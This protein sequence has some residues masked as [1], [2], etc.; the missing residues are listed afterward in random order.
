MWTP[1]LTARREQRRRARAAVL[2]SLAGFV[3]LQAAYFLVARCVPEFHDPEYCG[4]LAR[5]QVR[6]AEHPRA[7]PLVLVLG[8]SHVGMGVRP[9]VL[10]GAECPESPL[11]FNFGINAGTP[12]VSLVCL[13][14]LL[15]EGIRPDWVL[16]ETSALQLSADG[17][18]A[19]YHNALPLVFV[20]W[21][22][23]SV[24]GRYYAKPRRLWRDWV[25]TQSLPWFSHRQYLLSYLCRHWLPRGERQDVRWR[26]VDDWG[27]QRVR[28]HE[29]AYEA[30]LRRLEATRLACVEDY[31]HFAIGDITRR[32]LLEIVETCRRRHIGVAFLRMPEARVFQ[33]WCPPAVAD[34][35]DTFLAGLSKAHQI[36]LIDARDWVGE[37][38]F[39]DGHHLNPDGAEAFMRRFEAEVLRPLR[40]GQL[41][42]Q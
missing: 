31:R 5:L 28:G 6:L 25:V 29:G 16:V 21:Y 36:P 42:P 17:P 4:K 41:R 18:K 30:N 26:N 23:L 22:D 40:Q 14:R 9:G 32:A 33:S 1:G 3:S 7:H 19:E 27:W 24:L 39:S 20:R 10:T 37:A 12:M 15:A 2:W 35:A 13:R 34:Q 11:V 8:S 38:G